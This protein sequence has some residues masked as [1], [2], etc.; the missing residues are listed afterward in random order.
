MEPEVEH[1]RQTS[2][3]GQ[4][5]LAVLHEMAFAKS[6]VT[7]VGCDVTDEFDLPGR[8]ADE[9]HCSSRAQ[10]PGRRIGQQGGLGDVV[11]VTREGRPSV[12]FDAA[13]TGA[14]R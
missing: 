11:R 9:S 3:L 13:R 5:F 2:D 8:N 4:R 7:F 12:P 6:P 10:P 1:R 14:T